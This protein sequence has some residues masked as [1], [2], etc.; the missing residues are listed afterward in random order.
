VKPIVNLFIIL[1][2]IAGCGSSDDKIV[3]CAFQQDCPTGQV[4]IEGI[5]KGGAGDA[6]Y[7]GPDGT[8]QTPGDTAAS[9]DGKLPKPDITNPD[10]TLKPPDLTAPAV[11]SVLPVDGATNVPVS[12][13]TITVK[14][15]EPV[16][17]GVDE[18][19]FALVD[20][21]GDKVAG[22]YAVKPNTNNVEWTFTSSQSLFYASPYRAEI[23]G[24]LVR[25][26]DFAGNKMQGVTTVTFFTES[27]ANM[28]NY[29]Q[30]AFTYAPN[31]K[32]GTNKGISHY[33]YPTAT[34]FDGNE[35]LT[36]NKKNLTA[37]TLKSIKPYTYYTVIE[38]ESHYFI[39]YVWYWPARPNTNTGGEQSNGF[40]NDASGALVVVEKWSD[41]SAKQRPVEVLPWFKQKNGEYIR[42]Y[43]TK[44]SGI[45]HE[46]ELSKIKDSYDGVY[47]QAVLFENNRFQSWIPASLHQSCLWHDAGNA[48]VSC[49]LD[50][51]ARGTVKYLTLNPGTQSDP[52]NKGASWPDTGV[53]KYQLVDL[54]TTWWPRRTQFGTFVYGSTL[55]D[56][57]NYKGYKDAGKTIEVRFPNYFVNK[58]GEQSAG[59]PAWSVDWKPL[60]PGK[61]YTKIPHGTFFFNPAAYLKFRHC[62]S[63]DD[64]KSC[65]VAYFSTAFNVETKAGYSRNYCFNPYMRID[66]RGTAACP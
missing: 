32:M 38:S 31:V 29:N 1:L 15:N 10:T 55:K 65:D 54:I 48:P 39:N 66:A 24:E 14:F 19:T 26:Q 41:G 51:V 18:K 20:V 8:N 2:L 30:L 13:L 46:S 53:Y 27:P 35:D 21:N 3:E 22:I 64:S 62:G 42:A 44:E 47:E 6:S 58:D 23:N 9:P 4:C 60:E 63:A 34:N 11:V 37:D 28:G 61:S 5:C 43:P 59:R 33:E 16:K 7:L 52:I 56:L 57:N 45:Y 12:G 36:D 49:M 40:E 50:K 17:F 25:I